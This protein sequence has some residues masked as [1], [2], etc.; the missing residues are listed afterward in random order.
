MNFGKD[1]GFKINTQEYLAFLHTKNKTSHIF[2]L[3]TEQ[4]EKETIS[5]T[6][7]SKRIKYL[8]INLSKEAKYLYYKILMKAIKND[9][10][11]EIYHVLGLEKSILGK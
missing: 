8:E 11:R 3:R 6:I 9:T 5:F 7:S 4:K 2:T 10:N 1:S